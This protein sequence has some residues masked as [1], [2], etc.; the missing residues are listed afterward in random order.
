MLDN[1]PLTRRMEQPVIEDL[2]EE[3]EEA[4][5]IEVRV[6][7]HGELIHSELCESEDQASVIVD[8]WAEM[9]GAHCEVDNLSVH[10]HPGQIVEPE[11]D[12]PF[13]DDYPDQVEVDRRLPQKYQD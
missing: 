10:H 1:G 13:D 12:E 9:E 2:F 5:T 7:R 4:L 11:P 3:R 8:E 6:F